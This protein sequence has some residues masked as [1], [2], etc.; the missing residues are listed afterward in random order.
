MITFTYDSYSY[1]GQRTNQEDC[2]FPE[3]SGYD[4]R[5]FIVCDGMGGHKDGEVASG[6]VCRSLCSSLGHL[7]PES[8]D[9]TKFCD[10]VSK[11]YDALELDEVKHIGE[12]E[13]GT[14]L[15][16]LFMQ[17]QQAFV[18]HIGDSRLYQIRGNSIRFVTSDHSLVND[19]VKA[20]II[21]TEEAADYPRKNVITRAMQPFLENRYPA[22][23][24]I[25][26]DILPGDWF[27]LCTD[28]VVESVS[29]DALCTILSSS[30]G[31]ND[32]ISRIQALCKSS[33][34]DNNSAVLLRID[35]V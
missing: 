31:V 23:I 27:L 35:T 18:A 14:T 6:A 16:F 22:E 12:K 26:S 30:P 20:G 21:T 13:M 29:N 2:I 9:E 32:A 1:I 5:M 4:G 8:F 33:S 11:A 25:I 17:S 34:K 15:V 24:D 3:S 28:G 19:L 10:A 7:T